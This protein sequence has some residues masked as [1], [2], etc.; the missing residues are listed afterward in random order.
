MTDFKGQISNSHPTKAEL[1][2]VKKDQ[3]RTMLCGSARV[4]EKSI[5]RMATEN[6]SWGYVRI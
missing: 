1:E 3:C 4:V 6:V 5:V 2:G